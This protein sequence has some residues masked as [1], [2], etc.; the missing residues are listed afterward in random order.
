MKMPRVFAFEPDAKNSLPTCPVLTSTVVTFSV[1]TRKCPV[2]IMEAVN[3][4]CQEAIIKA[5]MKMHPNEIHF[6]KEQASTWASKRLRAPVVACVAD[7]FV[8][9]S[10][11]L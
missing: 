9:S 8:E 11:P 10:M 2:L 4:E 7:L 3:G 6:T 5:F 1:A